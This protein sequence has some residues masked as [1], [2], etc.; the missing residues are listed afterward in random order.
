MLIAG[1]PSGDLLAAELVTALRAELS[2]A[3]HFFGAGGPKL[4]QAGV[5]L[6]LDLT[7]HSVIG[8]WEAVSNYPKFRRYFNQLLTLASERRPDIVVCVDYQGFNSRFAAAVR[9][10]CRGIAGWTPRIVQYVSPQ[11][12]ASRPGRAKRLAA[13][14]DLLLSIIPFEKAWY[15]ERVPELKVEVVGHPIVDRYH[16]GGR[17]S[18]RAKMTDGA[19]VE[20]GPPMVLLLPGSRVGELKRHLP[21]M[22]DAVREIQREEPAATFRMVLPSEGLKKLADEASALRVEVQVG[23][24]ADA[25]R[26]A[27]V[28]IA[29]TGTVTLECAWFGVPTVAFYKTS[30]LTYAVGKRLVT[31]K[32]LAMP[33]LLAG[34]SVFPEFVQH[35]AT[36]PNLARAAL[37]LLRDEPRRRA[38]KAQLAKVV[39]SLGPPGASNRAAKAVLK[40]A[41]VTG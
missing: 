5:E 19:G 17:G 40:C 38:V 35:E 29:S 15:G 23:G 30:G 39:E 37:A 10:R 9:E 31:V 14:V 26:A 16:A 22:L 11:V 25:L 12:W 20:P 27:T 36:G 6:A 41:G 8:L 2:A 24:L 28:A 1:E 7:Q 18:T 33:N 3:P 34:E 21:P 32:F 4:A 13:N